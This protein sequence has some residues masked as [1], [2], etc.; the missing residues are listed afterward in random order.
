VNTYK[1][2]AQ[3]IKAMIDDGTLKPGKSVSLKQTAL[4]AGLKPGRCVE[5]LRGVLGMWMTDAFRGAGIEDV[6][7]EEVGSGRYRRYIFR[8]L[9]P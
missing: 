3:A 6:R 1:A 7:F 4:A 8:R 5:D 9:K 2:L